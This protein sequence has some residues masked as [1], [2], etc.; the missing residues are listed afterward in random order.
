[1]DFA[2]F[3]TFLFSRLLVVQKFIRFFTCLSLTPEDTVMCMGHCSC[4]VHF[5]LAAT[6]CP[7]EQMVGRKGLFYLRLTYF[8]VLCMYVCVRVPHSL[9][10]ELAISCH[11]GAGN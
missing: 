8:F 11:V 4:L 7:D 10:L 5:A 2:T 3:L 6:K 9:E 1:M